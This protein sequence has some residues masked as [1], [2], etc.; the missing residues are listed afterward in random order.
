M[1][2]G[3][4]GRPDQGP[5]QYSLI[6]TYFPIFFI[7]PSA[8]QVL[9]SRMCPQGC[10]FSFCCCCSATKLYPSFGDPMQSTHQ[11]SLSFTISQSLLIVMSTVLV[12][13]F[14]F[15]WPL[16]LLPSSSSY[17]TNMS[18]PLPGS[19]V[20]SFYR[21]LRSDGPEPQ[22]VGPQSITDSL[23]PTRY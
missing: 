2:P 23:P 21:K 3:P 6:K 12:M 22:A 5:G 20:S 15:C 19:G 9:M 8:I 1:V 16:R 18:K 4:L 14:T 13:H 10:C 7:Q 17:Y 11:A